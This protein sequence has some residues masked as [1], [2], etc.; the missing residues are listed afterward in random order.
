MTG[1]TIND[2]LD[3]LNVSEDML[4]YNSSIIESIGNNNGKIVYSY[5]NIII[6]TEINDMLYNELLKNPYIDFIETLPLKQYGGIDINLVGQTSSIDFSNIS[7]LN[8]NF[9][10]GMTNSSYEV[11]YGSVDTD[12][13]GYAPTI[14]NSDF[15]L[16]AL[17]NQWFSYDVFVSG[18][19]PL[20]FDFI[21]P[22][23]YIGEL[24]FKNVRTL[25]G[26]TSKIGTYNIVIRVS[27]N[28]DYDT[29]ILTLIVT[30]NTII[31][32]SSF[33]VYNKLG[34]YF[35]YIITSSG[36][37]PKTYSISGE[38]SGIYITGNSIYG[39]FLS[40]GIYNIGMSVSGVNGSDSK[41]LNV[42]VGVPPIINSNASISCEQ[43]SEF[44]YKIL[45]TPSTG[46]SYNVTGKLPNGLSFKVDTISGKPTTTGIYIVTL[47]AINPYGE[48]IKNLTITIY[49]MGT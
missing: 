1:S 26:M 41:V 30:E 9:D 48:N 23:N 6:A 42:N 3:L 5:D 29:K 22:Q 32:N 8:Y 15:V 33:N 37:S 12:S 17:T 4:K 11:V 36:P 34:T 31:T 18:S 39:Q 43:N 16:T 13:T 25:S 20:K 7:N 49:E 10:T 45:S 24:M 2:L 38:P 14:I 47:K 46:V 40:D 44:I 28:F 21:K 35:S 19:T 27:N